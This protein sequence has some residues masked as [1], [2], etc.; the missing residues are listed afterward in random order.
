[1]NINLDYK[2]YIAMILSNNIL[3]RKMRSS[4]YEYNLSRTQ[5][6]V[7]DKVFNRWK[8]LDSIRKLLQ[9]NSFQYLIKMQFILIVHEIN[10]NV[11]SLFCG[12]DVLEQESIHFFII[13]TGSCSCLSLYSSW[14][15]DRSS[16]CLLVCRF[17]VERNN[18]IIC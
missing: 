11:I 14:H 18:V 9:K 6:L 13:L 16:S 7:K 4:L 5:C 17:V 8:L 15:L 2:L 12:R 10:N 1:M 3:L